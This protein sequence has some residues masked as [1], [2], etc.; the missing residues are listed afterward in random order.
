MS[1][2]PIRCL[3]MKLPPTWLSP[4]SQAP[5]S[6]PKDWTT[7][8]K[9]ALQAQTRSTSHH[10]PLWLSPTFAGP[11]KCVASPLTLFSLISRWKCSPKDLPGAF[12][13]Q[14]VVSMEI[15]DD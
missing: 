13:H 1:S 2:L 7:N 9:G 3:E 4:S 10:P 12:L 5:S 8:P 11:H 14:K 6:L 15:K